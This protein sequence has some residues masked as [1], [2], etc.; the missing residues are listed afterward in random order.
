MNDMQCPEFEQRLNA[1]LDD[2]RNPEADPRL[3]AHADECEQCRQLLDAHLVLLAGLSHI[4][5]PAPSRSFSQRTLA[6][7]QPAPSPLASSVRFGKSRTAFGPLMAAA[8]VILLAVSLLWYARRNRSTT[9]DTAKEVARLILESQNSGLANANRGPIMLGTPAADWLIEMPRLPSRLRTYR[10]AIGDIAL[11][12][13]EAAQRLEEV[14]YFAPGIR[15]L[16]ASFSVIWD[17][18]FGTIPPSSHDSPRPSHS[19]TGLW[20]L[21]SRQVA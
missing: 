14:E 3:A 1:V 2:R 12:I 11:A 10:G 15:P 6:A 5:T 19:P 13:P 21:E 9:A 4:N 7:V 20:R 17:T 8:A 18:F 16:R